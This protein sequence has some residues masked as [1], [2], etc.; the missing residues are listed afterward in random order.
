[1]EIEV[2]DDGVV[3]P[4]APHL[5]RTHSLRTGARQRCACIFLVTVVKSWFRLQINKYLGHK[6]GGFKHTLWGQREIITLLFQEIIL[7]K[8]RIFHKSLVLDQ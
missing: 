2:G 1:M 7:S 3:G 8:G 6:Y 4:C 5:T